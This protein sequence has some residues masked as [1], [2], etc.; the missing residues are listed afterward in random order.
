MLVAGC[1]SIIQVRV[2]QQDTIEF[3]SLRCTRTLVF[4]RSFEIVRPGRQGSFYA[5]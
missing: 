4:Q 2:L 3:H 5:A 1:D